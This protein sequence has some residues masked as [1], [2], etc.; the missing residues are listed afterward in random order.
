LRV[1]AADGTSPLAPGQRESASIGIIRPRRGV[2]DFQWT[3]LNAEPCAHLTPACVPHRPLPSAGR[4]AQGGSFSAWVWTA[5]I[6]LPVDLRK[7]PD[8]VVQ[9]RGRVA[10]PRRRRTS[11]LEGEAYC[12]CAT[13]RRPD[14]H[15][16][17]VFKPQ[18]WSQGPV[19]LQTSTH[20]WV[21]VSQ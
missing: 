17:T 20:T 10:Y 15:G 21:S 5:T 1:G 18:A 9:R 11:C 8:Q 7:E 19:L 2:N 13:A 6:T 12:K 16:L 14:Y 3:P 4:A